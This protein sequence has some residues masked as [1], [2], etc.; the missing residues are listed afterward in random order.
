MLTLIVAVV[1][2]LQA[3]ASDPLLARLVGVW[4]GTG[5]VLGQPARVHMEWAP[6][7]DG[8]F[9]RLMFVN[10]IGPADKARKFEGHAYYRLAEDGTSYR[11]TW[12]DNS[13]AIRP[14]EARRDGDALVARWG[15]PQTEEGETT[16]RFES[17]TH[18]EVVDR[19]KSRD[20]SWREFGRVAL[21]RK[22]P[23]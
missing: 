7:L 3:A 5:T 21:K 22:E 4:T 6:T 17:S 16:Y 20:G 1:L 9:V 11:G 18:L 14:I 8:S 23:R 15:T 13:G 10:D 19:V 2:T 12:M